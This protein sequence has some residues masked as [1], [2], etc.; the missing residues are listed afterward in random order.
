MINI[1][2]KWIVKLVVVINQN[3]Y[4]EP[5]DFCKFGMIRVKVNVNNKRSIK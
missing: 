4:L 3:F 1:I 2:K 5:F